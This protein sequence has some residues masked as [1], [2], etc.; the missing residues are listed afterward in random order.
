M[1]KQQ[2][3]HYIEHQEKRVRI[4]GIPCILEHDHYVI[5]QTEELQQL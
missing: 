5:V 2:C 3:Q 1:V 4:P